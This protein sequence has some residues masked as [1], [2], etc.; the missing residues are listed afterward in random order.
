ML[1]IGV[2][3]LTHLSDQTEIEGKRSIEKRTRDREGEREFKV[4]RSIRGDF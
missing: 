1:C 4:R 3:W 2:G